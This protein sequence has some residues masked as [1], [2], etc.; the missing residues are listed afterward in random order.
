MQLRILLAC[1][2]WSANKS[3]LKIGLRSLINI[4][5]IDN[6][7]VKEVI[8]GDTIKLQNNIDLRLENVNAPEMD[9]SGGIAAKNKLEQLVGGEA[10][11]YTEE[12][13]DTY[14]RIVS[15]VY[16]NGTHVNEEMRKYLD[17]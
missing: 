11:R 7:I 14:G 4:K 5:Q 6:G 16:V 15:N 17:Q 3:N 8:D 9:K 10:I 12:A 1:P 13:R 2:I